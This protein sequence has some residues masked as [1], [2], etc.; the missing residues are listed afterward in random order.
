MA[1]GMRNRYDD[2]SELSANI[3][4][5]VDAPKFQTRVRLTFCR[6]P[7][8]R[9]KRPNSATRSVAHN[10]AAEAAGQRTAARRVQRLSWVAGHCRFSFP[11]ERV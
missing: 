7:G 2:E 9:P 8:A 10:R 3:R 6:S 4:E 1:V 5:A 11:R